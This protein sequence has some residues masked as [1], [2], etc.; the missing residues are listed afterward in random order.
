MNKKTCIRF[1]TIADYEAEERW[2]RE[3]YRKGWRPYRFIV[4]CFYT[5]SST[6]PK[7]MAFKLEFNEAPMESEPEYQSLLRDY[8]WE[9]L[10]SCMDWRYCC[11]PADSGEDENELFTDD[12]SKL[13]MISRIAKRRFIPLTVLFLCCVI[14]NAC[15]A[16]FGS[17]LGWGWTVF[18]LL[19]LGIYV[20]LLLRCGLGLRKLRKKYS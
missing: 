15:Q 7:D 6:E 13:K 16:L 8:G 12:A 4:P 18:W 19:M 17:G 3:M 9:Y 1:Y 20:Y 10:F 14:P 2:L 11:K 5:F